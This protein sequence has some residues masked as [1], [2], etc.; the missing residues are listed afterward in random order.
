MEHFGNEYTMTFY[1][2]DAA[3]SNKSMI[4]VYREEMECKVQKEI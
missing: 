2:I 1:L 3:N 4:R